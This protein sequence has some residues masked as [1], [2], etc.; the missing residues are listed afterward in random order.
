L[1]PCVSCC[2]C[3]CCCCVLLVSGEDDGFLLVYCYDPSAD[4]SSLMV[5]DAKTM[6]NVPLAQVRTEPEPD[7]G[8]EGR[9]GGLVGCQPVHQVHHVMAQWGPQWGPQCTAAATNSWCQL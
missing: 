5:Y 1:T 3:C 8:E 6:S 7:R 4:C 2:C 9:L